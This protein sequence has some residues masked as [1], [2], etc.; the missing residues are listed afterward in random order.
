M[1]KILALSRMEL[2]F[3]VRRGSF[4][5][6]YM[7]LFALSVLLVHVISGAF[8]SVQVM[9][10]TTKTNGPQMVDALATSILLIT[11]FIIS[12]IAGGGAMRDFRYG[13]HEITFTFPI[14]KG[15]YI[16]GKFIGLYLSCLLLFTAPLLGY[17]LSCAAPWLNRELFVPFTISTYIHVF[18]QKY[19]ITIFFFSTAFFTLGLLIRNVVIN[20]VTLIMLYVL[21]ALAGKFYGQTAT[22]TLGAL[23]DPLG[24]YA[25]A[26]I[27]LGNTKGQ[28]NTQQIPLTGLLL[29]NR[30]LWTG[31]GFLLLSFTIWRF[32]FSHQVFSLKLKRQIIPGPRPG[33]KLI[34]LPQP[35][36]HPTFKGAFLRNTFFSQLRLEC[37]HIFR[38]PY[39][40]I[41]GGTAI[42]FLTI[43]AATIG[44]LMETPGY[45]TTIRV[46]QSFSGAMG[47]F[48]LLLIM[49]F[50]GEAVWRD[51][52]YRLDGIAGS[53]PASPVIRLAAKT[54]AVFI[55]VLLML[56]LIMICGL[57][58]QLASPYYH[59]NIPLYLQYLFAYEGVNYLYYCILAVG[60]QAFVKGKYH[61]YFLFVLVFIFF[62]YFGR[63]LFDQGFLVPGHV[64]DVDYS[65]IAGFQGAFYPFYVFAI[66]WLLFA[67]LVWRAGARIWAMSSEPH[68]KLRF[69][70]LLSGGLRGRSKTTLLVGACFV[71]LGLFIAYNTNIL[72]EHHNAEYYNKLRAGYEQ[73]YT[74]LRRVPQLSIT[75]VKGKLDIFPENR[76]LKARME[77]VLTNK[78][79]VPVD[80]IYINLTD[81]K[82]YK[83]WQSSSSWKAILKDDKTDFYGYRF[84][85]P[86]KPGDSIVLSYDFDYAPKGFTDDGAGSIVNENGTF[87][88][89]TVFLPVIGYNAAG[90]LDGNVLRKKYNLPSKPYALAQTDPVGLQ[91][92]MLGQG[93]DRIH[94]QL[95]IGTTT[96]Q[97][98]IAPGYLLK[99][100]EQDGRSYFEYQMDQPAVNYFSIQSGR[101]QVLTESYQPDSAQQPV[102]LSVYYHK[103]HAYN[104]GLMMTGMKD[105]LSYFGG[106]FSP[107][108]YRQLRIIEFPSSSFAQ[109]FANTIPFSE[110]IGFLADLRDTT[111]SKLSR[112]P[113]D[114]V[115]Y[116]TAHEVAHQWWAHQ[117]LPAN[118]EG[119]NFL[120]ETMAQYSALMLMK[121]KYGEQR[122]RQFLEMESYNY[123]SGRGSE[124][125]EERPLANVLM[126]QQYIF[127]NK[128]AC[129]MYA[130]QHYLGEDRM[131]QVIKEYIRDNAFRER[132]YV[133]AND[134]ISRIKNAA[135]DSLKYL[136][137]DCLEKIVLYENEIK[138]AVTLPGYTAGEHTLEATING[139]KLLYTR[140]GQENEVP[141]DDWITVGLYNKK[142]S[143]LA[144]RILKLHSGINKV[145]VRAPYPVA[146]LMLN[147]DFDLQ[148]KN[149]FSRKLKTEVK[150]GK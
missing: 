128:G 58:V 135:P 65:D 10:D 139:R 75:S 48:M 26:A 70:S 125:K 57:L 29:W 85:Q 76:T 116:V 109:S 2:Y 142:D 96:G 43:S 4:I 88:N 14:S 7:V 100:W 91:Q 74:A 21:Y 37:R 33:A 5:I 73:Q 106:H 41:I 97:T 20:W 66:Y 136:V 138:S 68:L 9:S 140:K 32:R 18:L 24:Q 35:L 149:Y 102:Q 146:R 126:E 95:T 87:I 67:I 51:A 8:S 17:A 72:N 6:Y 132:P 77:L 38:S 120:C 34:E 119:A 98:A 61:G 39:F 78:N 86:I 56:V 103:D 133:T 28:N 123:L 94:L 53:T 147:P 112:S 83:N 121:H 3:S 150:Q 50:S 89:N 45:P 71:G 64:P 99:K 40:Y 11:T 47:I 42:L 63:K 113:V 108:Q 104:I 130:L 44:Q 46:V 117:I 111:A 105:A 81:H 19:M 23:L 49:V 27:S 55:P 59:F 16:L 52:Q 62:S 54:M 12:T 30:L 127:Y 60:L 36:T 82:Y 101:Y 1:K 134:F 92:N 118:T 137:S 84:S 107:Y 144:T 93:A 79:T 15:Q 131:N 115:Y 110:N 148:E 143:L 31:V 114:Y 22:R 69:K 124:S 90:E 141:M 145:I 80:S 129:A 13:S 122:V 25:T